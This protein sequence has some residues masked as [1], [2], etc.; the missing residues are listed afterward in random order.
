MIF[1]HGAG[2]YVFTLFD[3]FA[4]NVPL[5]IIA[6]FEC[7]AVSYVYGVNRYAASSIGPHFQ[8]I[9]QSIDQYL[10]EFCM[11]IVSPRTLN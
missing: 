4:G 2:N 3:D 7:I 11:F 10:D 8:S 1:T 5:L 9:N 6:F